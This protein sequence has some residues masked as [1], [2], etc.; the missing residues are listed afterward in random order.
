M[1]CAT[2]R[3]KLRL[4]AVQVVGRAFTDVVCQH[5]SPER[6]CKFPLHAWLAEN[7]RKT[8]DTRQVGLVLHHGSLG[9]R[10]GIVPKYFRAGATSP[11]GQVSTGPLFSLT[12]D[13][14][15]YDVRGSIDERSTG[16]TELAA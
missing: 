1:R 5:W 16:S 13:L 10:L 11:V 14:G 7:S 8:N 4:V 6:P 15:D 3:L 12:A 2:D 9:T